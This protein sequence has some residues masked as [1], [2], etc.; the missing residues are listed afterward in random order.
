M[1][2]PKHQ[3]NENDPPYGRIVY[4]SEGVVLSNQQRDSQ[5]KIP[6]ISFI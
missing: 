2:S 1:H 5:F 3:T 6:L 4:E